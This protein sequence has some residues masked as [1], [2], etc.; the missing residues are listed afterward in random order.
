MTV[1]AT[2]FGLSAWAIR[3]GRWELPESAAISKCAEDLQ[4]AMR[5]EYITYKRGRKVRKL[6][7][8]AVRS[9]GQQMVL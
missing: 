6:H 8:A 9:G 5:E 4:S 2:W 1:S 3:T 7:P